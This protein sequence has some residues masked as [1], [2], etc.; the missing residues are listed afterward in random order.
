LSFGPRG[1]SDNGFTFN[2]PEG[3]SKIT[4]SYANKADGKTFNIE[5]VWTG[6]VASNKITLKK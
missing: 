3:E 2:L 6:T 4:I 5:G 1:A